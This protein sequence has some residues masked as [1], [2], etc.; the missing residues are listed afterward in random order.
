MKV[1]VVGTGYVGLVLGVCLAETGND[2][3][4]VDIDPKKVARLSK[5]EVPIYEPG[6]EEM[7]QRNLAEGRL[8]FTTDLAVAYPECEL[9]FLALPTPP[10]ADGSADLQY[11]LGVARQIG[12]LMNRQSG[13]KVIINKSTVP[14]GTSD[15]VRDAIMSELDRP[16]ECPFDVAS[17]PEFLKEGA[18]VQDCMVPDRVVIGTRSER[19]Q[20]LLKE[21]YQPFMRTDERFLLMDERSAELTKYA[22]NAFLAT[23]I[24]FMNEMATLCDLLGA[25]VDLVRKGIGSD[26]RIGAK[27]LFPGTGYGGSC[28][29]KDVKALLH[30][31]R[32][33]GHEPRILA[34]VEAVNNEQKRVLLPKMEA[35]Y[36]PSLVGKRIAVWGLAF[37]PKTDDMREAPSIPVVQ[38]LLR[39][40]AEVHVHDPV[41]MEVAEGVFGEAVTYHEA[42]YDALEGAD[43][44]VV[45][46][47]WNEFRRPDFSRMKALMRTPIIFDGRNIYD[48][49]RMRDLGFD[50]VCIGRNTAHGLAPAAQSAAGA[51]QPG[52][53]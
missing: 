21:L 32:E 47:E 10:G 31:G 12:R 1:C 46:T 4:G 26:D 29:P 51:A 13:Y 20:V 23:K 7:L 50:Y 30:T 8:R 18:A 39:R 45:M 53:A 16:D 28:F 52:V 34:A 24:S 36:G 42:N 35:F 6:L 3:I 49:K 19:A 5:G 27:F 17:N 44:L 38:E 2:V 33:S 15:R 48:P 41:A 43:G 11:V 37:K 40:G 9:I 22:A 25:D 14:V